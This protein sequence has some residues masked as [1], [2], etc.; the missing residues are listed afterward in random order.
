MTNYQV[1][2]GTI[3]LMSNIYTDS[4]KMNNLINY[5]IGSGYPRGTGVFTGTTATVATVPYDNG[6]YVS[7]GYYMIDFYNNRMPFINQL[8][9]DFVSEDFQ[10]LDII[11]E[12]L[13][14]QGN[15]ANASSVHS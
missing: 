10:Q 14:F 7:D 9:E 15:F 3:P 12:I 1:N 2:S 13:V 4:Q 6:E 8:L 5:R 11:Q